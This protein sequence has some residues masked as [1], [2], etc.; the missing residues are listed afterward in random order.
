MQVAG[1]TMWQ[2]T[3][4]EFEL[5]NQGCPVENCL[6]PLRDFLLFSGQNAA[7]SPSVL[8]DLEAIVPSLP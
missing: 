3:L 2:R 5:E 7:V 1:Q 6:R 4:E 8:I